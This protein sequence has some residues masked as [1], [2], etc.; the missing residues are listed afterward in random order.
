M[1]LNYDEANVPPRRNFQSN[2]VA[3]MVYI[4]FVTELIYGCSGWKVAGIVRN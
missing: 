1:R 2:T 4:S 3:V